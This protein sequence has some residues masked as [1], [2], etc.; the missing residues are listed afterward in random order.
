MIG[1]AQSIVVAP[2]RVDDAVGDLRFGVLIIFV[3]LFTVVFGRLFCGWACPQTVFMEM[4]FR[5]IEF[6]IEG[7]HVQQKRLRNAPWTADKVKKRVLK[8]TIFI[9]IAFL[10]GNLL[11]AYIVGKDETFAIITSPPSE[12]WVGFLLVMAF[13]G[14][15]FFNFAY[16]R[17]QVCTV[18]CPYGRLQ[19]VLLDNKSI[20]VAYDH[21]RGEPRELP[22]KQRS[23]G[24]GDCIDCFACVDVCPTG[25]DIRNGT[26]LECVNCTACIDACD[27]IMDKVKK[28]RGLVRYAS[29]HDIQHGKETKFNARVI[30]YSAVLVLILGIFTTLLATRPD[31]EATIIKA[32]GSLYSVDERDYIKNIFNVQVAN[33]TYQEFDI[34]LKMDPSWQAE[35][36]EVGNRISVDPE[37]NSEGIF[38]LS[39]PRSK[40]PR[41][42]TKV[43]VQIWSGDKLIDEVDVKFLRP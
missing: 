34:Q 5:K 38:T 23:E 36:V 30:A 32:R 20:L 12:N 27:E 40:L 6:W 29:E 3:I 35:I 16:F 19:G 9:F 33:K 14:I 39:I 17:E 11:M 42:S 15:T 8:Y 10:I 18:V 43:P 7:N 21:Q 24:A 1:D 28:P 2:R 41:K 26:Q 13:T 25:I 4:V 37:S 22:R 31:V